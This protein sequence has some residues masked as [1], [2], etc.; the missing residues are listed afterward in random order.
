MW[1]EVSGRCFYIRDG[2]FFFGTWNSASSNE[3]REGEFW[4]CEISCCRVY[5]T[6]KKMRMSYT[7]ILACSSSC[8][9]EVSSKVERRRF[10]CY[11]VVDV[12]TA[13]AAREH[14]LRSRRVS[15]QEVMTGAVVIENSRRSIYDISSSSIAMRRDCKGFSHWD[16]WAL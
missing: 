10:I 9:H 1:V 12:E 15:L 5:G 16:S 3:E 8:E 14:V 2:N 7:G 6:G 13:Q 11:V 4:C